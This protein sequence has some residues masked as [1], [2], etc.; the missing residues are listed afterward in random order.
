[1]RDENEFLEDILE[2]IESI[3]KYSSKGKAVFEK[4]ELIQNWVLRYLQ[5]I[6][7]AAS[8]ISKATQDQHPEVPWKKMVGMRNIIVHG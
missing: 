1:M 6:G 3:E 5:I 2:A 7:E 4:D 8:K